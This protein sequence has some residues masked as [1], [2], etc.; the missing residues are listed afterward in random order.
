MIKPIQ[1]TTCLKSIRTILLSSAFGALVACGGGSSGS[2]N[3]SNDMTNDMQVI[4]QSGTVLTPPSCEGNEIW[5]FGTSDFIQDGLSFISET[6][7]LPNQNSRFPCLDFLEYVPSANC[8]LIGTFEDIVEEFEFDGS[9]ISTIGVSA[10][11][12]VVVGTDDSEN[13]GAPAALSIDFLTDLPDC[14]LQ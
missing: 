3:M 13:F 14:V 11:N 8:S 4:T 2:N 6:E 1:S 5:D 7:G 9:L 10:E 12:L